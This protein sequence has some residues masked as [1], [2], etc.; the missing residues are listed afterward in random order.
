MLLVNDVSAGYGKL[1][2]LYGVNVEVSR[3]SIVALLGPN[4]SGKSTLLKTVF[5]LTTV[6]SGTVTYNGRDITYMPPHARARLGIAY[7]PQVG[8]VFGNL[9][10]EENLKM[11]A[12]TISRDTFLERL[13]KVYGLFPILRE[14]RKRRAGQLSG[15]QRQMLGIAMALVR[16]AKLIILD[17]PTAMLAPKAAQEIA[18]TIVELRRSG[19]TILLA[20]QNAMLAMD[21]ADKVYILASGRVIFE[22]PPSDLLARPDLGKLYLGLAR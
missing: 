18:D 5:G 3:G 2:I 8:N 19:I 14:F 9:T 1:Q 21:I 15:G 17:E 13:D 10:V 12:Y 20:E 4:G 7:L 6:Y 16:D 11:A 22:G